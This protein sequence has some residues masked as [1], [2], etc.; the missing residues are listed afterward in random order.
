MLRPVSGWYI[1]VFF[2]LLCPIPH[3]P[4]GLLGPP[5]EERSGRKRG[6]PSAV[7]VLGAGAPGCAASGIRCTSTRVL[8]C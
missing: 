4:Q 3:E 8:G 1:S 2:F 7:R 6:S 5:G